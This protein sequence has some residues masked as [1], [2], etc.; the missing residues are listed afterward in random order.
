[1]TEKQLQINSL[2]LAQ[3]VEWYKKGWLI[4]KNNPIQWILILVVFF[5][6]SILFNLVP[7]AGSFVYM[8]ISPALI[9]GIFLATKKSANGEEIEVMDLFSVLAD[10]SIRNNFFIL[11]ALTAV[12]NFLIIAL[13]LGPM[14][15]AAGMSHIMGSDGMMPAAVAGAGLGSLFLILPLIILYVMAMVYAIPLILFS[16]QKVKPALILSIKASVSNI[17]P[18][19]VA[20]VIYFLLAIIAMIPMGLGFLVLFPMTFG[21]IY[22]SYK[23]IFS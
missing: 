13:M 22:A 12:F 11:G 14:M 6:S 8:L 20:S 17:L 5:I 2:T 9:A 23:D 3:P 7:V 16:Q 1:M 21:A 18:M 19:F 4:F 10:A 15:G